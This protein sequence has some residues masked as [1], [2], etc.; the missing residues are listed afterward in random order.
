MNGKILIATKTG[1]KWA[2]IESVLTATENGCEWKDI[3]M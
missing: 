1:T 3:A 2:T